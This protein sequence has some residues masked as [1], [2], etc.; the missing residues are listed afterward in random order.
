MELTACPMW[1]ECENAYQ[2]KKAKYQDIHSKGWSTWG[3]VVED[4]QPSLPGEQWQPWESKEKPEEQEYRDCRQQFLSH[5]ADYGGEEQWR[6]ENSAI[7]TDGQWFGQ[8][9]LTHHPE[10]VPG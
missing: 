8:W 5:H 6:A 4:F 1:R 9:L 2:R 3:L 10:D 7:S